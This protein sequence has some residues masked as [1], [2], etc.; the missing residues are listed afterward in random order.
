MKFLVILA[1]TVITFVAADGGEYVP[2]SFYFLDENGN[3]SIPQPINQDTLSR[4]RRQSNFNPNFGGFAFPQPV[5]NFPQIQPGQ[6]QGSFVST[7]QTLSSRFGEDEP[8]VT[9]QTQTFHTSG[10]QYQQTTTNLRPDGTV[11]TNKQSGR[12]KREVS[13]TKSQGSD[14]GKAQLQ[15][16]STR[17]DTQTQPEKSRTQSQGNV[18]TVTKG[19]FDHIQESEDEP[20]KPL[21]ENLQRTPQQQ[22]QQHAPHVGSNSNV[23]PQQP[24]YPQQ[25]GNQQQPFYPPTGQQFPFGFGS[26]GFQQN[27][28]FPQPGFFPQQGFGF[29]QQSGFGGFPQQGFAPPPPSQQGVGQGAQTTFVGGVSSL[30]NRFGEDEGPVVTGGSQTITS[31]NGNYQITSSVLRPDGQVVTT[32]QSGKFPS[33][34]T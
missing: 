15:S 4:V 2:K 1:V 34:K 6:G 25:Q 9:G 17:G 8:V 13:Q 23:P 22:Q 20:T 33:K 19:S 18:P 5:F 21:N 31:Q 12:V 32:Q 29:P 7:S 27:P 10:G 3:P 24:Y 16:Q 30:D 14:D 26:F 28:F 11:T